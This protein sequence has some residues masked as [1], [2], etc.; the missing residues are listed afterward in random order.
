MVFPN[1]LIWQSPPPPAADLYCP[2]SPSDQAINHRLA[3]AK[4]LC[5]FLALLGSWIFLDQTT[6]PY[7]ATLYVLLCSQT[8]GSDRV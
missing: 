4:L 3:T 8:T 2:I 7:C 6:N 1:S 5:F